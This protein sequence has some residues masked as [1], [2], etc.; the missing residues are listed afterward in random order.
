MRVTRIFPS[1]CKE[2]PGQALDH[3]GPLFIHGVEGAWTQ[4]RAVL[5]PKALSRMMYKDIR[6]KAF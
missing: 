6:G 2:K 1:N 5:L 3:F 4:S